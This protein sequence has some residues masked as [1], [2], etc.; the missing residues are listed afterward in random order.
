MFDDLILQL[1]EAI[2]S[3]EA[4]SDKGWPVTFGA[5]NVDVPTLKQALALPKT[6]VF[7]EEAINYWKQ[8]QLTGHDSAEAGR[9]ALAALEQGNLVA[10][11]DALYFAQYLEK[12]VAEHS[13]TWLPLYEA[14]MAR[15]AA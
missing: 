11:S 1:R 10:A 15:R 5:R 12:P 13:R 2:E 9:K 6:C 3:S 7:R 8:A 14:I 4:W